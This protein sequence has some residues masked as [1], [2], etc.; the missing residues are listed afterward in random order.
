M[1]PSDV[2]VLVSPR[3]LDPSERLSATYCLHQI[4]MIRSGL[5]GS[6]P[7]MRNPIS[8]E[9]NELDDFDDDLGGRAA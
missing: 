7:A 3:E 2:I 5:S 4:S 6:T 9:V 1:K 8:T